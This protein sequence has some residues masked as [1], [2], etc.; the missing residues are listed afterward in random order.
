MKSEKISF[1]EFML[2][3][4]KKE[5]YVPNEFELLH[6]KLLS[7]YDITKQYDFLF[8]LLELSDY[9]K[10]EFKEVTK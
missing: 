1:Y 3:E 10:N 9:D 4:W 7:Y 6:I 5:N 2:E 8:K